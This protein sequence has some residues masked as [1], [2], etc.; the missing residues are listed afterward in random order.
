MDIEALSTSMSQSALS[1]AI[2]IKVLNL[3]KGQAVQQSQDLI[4]M[5]SASLDPNLGKSLDIRV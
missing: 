4:Q 3:A 1:Q 5:M 2:G